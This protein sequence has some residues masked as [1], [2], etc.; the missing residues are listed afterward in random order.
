VT[1]KS[2]KILI[3]DLKERKPVERNEEISQSLSSG[4][5]V[6]D[7]FEFENRNNI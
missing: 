5:I 7:F 6:I 4:E 1:K 2:A 3:L